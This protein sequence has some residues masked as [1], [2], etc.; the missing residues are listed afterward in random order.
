MST[1]RSGVVEYRERAF[2]QDAA[3]AIRGDVV[4]ALIEL[5][6]NSDDAYAGDQGSIAI[7]IERNE[8]DKFP[9]LIRVQDQA[10][11][12]SADDMIENFAVLGNEKEEKDELVRGL[13]GRGAKDVATLGPVRFKA[14]KDGKYS[15]LALDPRGHWRMLAE[16][17]PAT[18]LN[19][20]DLSLGPSDNGLTVDLSIKAGVSVPSRLKLQDRISGHAQLRDLVRRRRIFLADNR[21]KVSGSVEL[22]A[23]AEAGEIVVDEDLLVS[24]Y[25][26]V[27]LVVR[28]IPQRGTGSVGPYSTHGL[29]LRSGVS[30]FE[31][32]WFDLESRQEAAFFSGSIEAPQISDVIHAYDKGDHQLGGPTRLLSRSRDGLIKE[33]PYRKALSTAVTGRMKPVFDEMAQNMDANRHQGAA[34]DNALN[35][36]REALR[37]QIRELLEEIEENDEGPGADVVA[38]LAVIPPRRVA[39]PNESLTFTVRAT[40]APSGELIA[41]VDHAHPQDA[42]ASVAASA[43]GWSKHPRL[44]AVQTTIFAT[45]GSEEGTAVLRVEADGYTAFA[46]VV[47]RES[48]EAEDAA[49]E[50]LEVVPEVARIS[51]GRRKRFVLRAPMSL[52]GLEIKVSCDP[53]GANVPEQVVLHPEP[54]G[55]WAQATVVA[56]AHQKLTAV[57]IRFWSSE[58]EAKAV[59]TVEESP[60]RGGMDMDV[61][62]S[63]YR[64]PSRRSELTLDG[65]TIRIRVFPLHASFD[66]VFGKYSEADEKFADEDSSEA[67]AVL[68]EVIASELAG[69]FTERDYDKRPDRLDDAPR[70]LRRRMEICSRLLPPLHRSLRSGI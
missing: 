5:I 66:G 62:L 59:L 25:Q 14:I 24:G 9:I 3:E 45:A 10:T 67:R 47:V 36:A 50:V 55:R 21:D 33:H 54:G 2:E 38:P 19:R 31:N 53:D 49:P 37:D 48:S 70:V 26:P 17:V 57:P 30:T 42:I 13:F 4:R 1:L 58:Q 68:A 32:T 22:Q 64:K 15:E 11:G 51:P 40:V 43:T 41:G 35:V 44:D 65:G 69:Y 61:K 52:E 39:F 28:K 29:L 8:D 20:A 12:L 7:V 46:T 23:P 34:L 27:R 16:D 6:T 63:G 60:I 18:N 56:Q